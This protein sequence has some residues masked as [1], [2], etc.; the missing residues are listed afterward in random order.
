MLFVLVLFSF[1]AIC[2]RCEAGS[3][4][5]N[6]TDRALAAINKVNNFAAFLLSQLNKAL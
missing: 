3:E 5:F 2:H 6:K 1:Q 4:E